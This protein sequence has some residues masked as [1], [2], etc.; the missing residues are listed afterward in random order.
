MASLRRPVQALTSAFRP[1]LLIRAGTVVGGALGNAYLTGMVSSYLP[2]MLAS[3]PGNYAVGLGTAGLMGAALGALPM[4]R[5]V[6][7]DVFFGGVIEVATRA[8]KEYVVPMIPGLSGLGDY[9]STAD[10]AGAR[11]LGDYLTPANAASAR[12]LGDYYGGDHYIAE[13]LAGYQGASL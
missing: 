9:L 3:G 4:T 2:S 8:I 12:P 13:E 6:A 7:G 10:A 5:N 1:K 11:P